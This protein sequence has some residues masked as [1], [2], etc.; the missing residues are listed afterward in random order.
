M[1]QL[2][3]IY[4]RKHERDLPKEKQFSDTSFVR[5]SLKFWVEAKARTLSFSLVVLSFSH[6][7]PMLLSGLL[8]VFF[9]AARSVLHSFLLGLSLSL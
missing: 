5:K 6:L 3:E 9:S 8:L 1:L 4:D 2:S 7:I